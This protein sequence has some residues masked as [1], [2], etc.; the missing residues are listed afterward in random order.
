V[1]V[2]TGSFDV[3]QFFLEVFLKLC[4]HNY[5]VLCVYCFC[6]TSAV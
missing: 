5:D 2:E 4:V 3:C 1:F 6:F